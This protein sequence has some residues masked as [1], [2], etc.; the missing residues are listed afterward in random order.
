MAHLIGKALCPIARELQ[1]R[2]QEVGVWRLEELGFFSGH[3]G[4]NILENTAL[5]AG[6]LDD[7]SYKPHITQRF[8]E[9]NRK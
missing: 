4:E 9:T 6:L 8:R 2:G 5:I 1:R 7:I 3:L